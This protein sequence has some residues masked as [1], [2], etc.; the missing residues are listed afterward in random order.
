MFRMAFHKSICSNI[1]SSS[2]WHM[3]NKG[4]P[5]LS[6][7]KW[8]RQ[9][10]NIA[11][12][13]VFSKVVE[14][15]SIWAEVFKQTIEQHVQYRSTFKEILREER[16]LDD[17]RK[18]EVQY[19]SK[20]NKL[21]KQVEQ[22]KRKSDINKSKAL[23]EEVAETLSL[24]EESHAELEVKITKHEIFKAKK[25]KDALYFK[26]ESIEKFAKQA[27]SVSTAYK[28]LADLIPDTPTQLSEEKIFQGAG[29]ARRIVTDLAK[30]LELDPVV[31][32]DEEKS[33][34]T[35]LYAVSALKPTKATDSPPPSPSADP[36][37]RKLTAVTSDGL[38]SRNTVHDSLLTQRFGHA[39][40][41]DDLRPPPSCPPPPLPLQG[42]LAKG[43]RDQTFGKPQ[44]LEELTPP[45]PPPR[46]KGA[47][48]NKES[49]RWY[50][51]S[52]V[53]EEESDS[54]DSDGYTEPWIDPN[55]GY[56]SLSRH[57]NKCTTTKQTSLD[58]PRTVGN[59]VQFSYQSLQTSGD[60]HYDGCYLQLKQ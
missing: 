13:D 45:A 43:L 29:Q 24:S 18:R 54:A 22:N 51:R 50:A 42:R 58:D 21:Q 39:L 60:V 27:L 46:R 52:K 10:E 5:S 30:E 37:H 8:A 33:D 19:A 4:L 7:L 17:M 56:K 9:E 12:E 15:G 11:L 28:D 53:W 26:S 31:I 6:L 55:T 59:N 57:N 40:S 47:S 44:S 36:K 16:I 25:L 32:A 23:S 20:L 48:R 34:H 49:N 35:Y 2:G 3:N 1:Q 38:Q 41:L 14:V